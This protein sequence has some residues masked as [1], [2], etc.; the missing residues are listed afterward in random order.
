[1]NDPEPRLLPT[2]LLML[3]V[4]SSMAFLGGCVAE[5]EQ[6]A[7]APMPIP[8]TAVKI[9][10][11]DVPV[12]AEFVGKTA[13]SRRVEVRSRVEGFL[14]SRDYE[15]GT[16]VHKGQVMFRMDLKPFEAQLQAAKAE[17]SQQLARQATADADLERAVPLA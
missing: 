12:S 1:M 10:A 6:A 8:V 14:Q 5:D 17:L 9:V 3:V 13:S 2:R 7:P 16:L 4:L 11:K 15:E